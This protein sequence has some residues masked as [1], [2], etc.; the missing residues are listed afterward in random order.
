MAIEIITKAPT[1]YRDTCTH[2]GTEFRYGL[3]DIVNHLGT[4]Y[5]PCPGCGQRVYHCDQRCQ[6]RRNGVA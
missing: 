3:T 6:S 5:V 4:P 2:C 1:A